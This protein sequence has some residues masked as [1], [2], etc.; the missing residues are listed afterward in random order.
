MTSTPLSRLGWTEEWECSTCGAA[1]PTAAA[2]HHRCRMASA[3]FR[4][5]RK[6]EP[7]VLSR[8]IGLLALM[9]FVLWP[10]WAGRWR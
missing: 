4:P 8:L 2:Y 5:A 6:E 7:M 3:R 10:L 9:V 1:M